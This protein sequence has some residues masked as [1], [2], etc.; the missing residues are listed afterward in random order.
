MGKSLSE[1][2]EKSTVTPDENGSKQ[3]NLIG[4][5]KKWEKNLIVDAIVA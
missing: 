5:T 1:S 2:L 4:T 3:I